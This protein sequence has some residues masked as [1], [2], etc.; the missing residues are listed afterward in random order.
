MENESLI[1][2][3][4]NVPQLQRLTKR[5]LHARIVLF[6]V[7][8]FCLLFA[9]LGAAVYAFLS[10]SEPEKQDAIL[11]LLLFGGLGALLLVCAIVSKH[12]AYIALAIS[13]VTFLLAVLF[14]A[15]GF[16]VADSDY[17]LFSF[18]FVAMLLAIALLLLRGALAAKRHKELSSVTL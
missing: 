4:D 15:I 12:S 13:A 5:I 17:S 10:N 11:V 16:F 3:T 7:S 1:F 9:M 2:T 6:V 14:V 8:V 18:G